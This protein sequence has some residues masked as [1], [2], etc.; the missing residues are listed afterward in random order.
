[1]L[2]VKDMFGDELDD[3]DHRDWRIH[4]RYTFK[5]KVNTRNYLFSMGKLDG[6][7]LRTPPHPA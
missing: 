5:D 2:Y 7:T 1:M 6:T 4:P 3:P